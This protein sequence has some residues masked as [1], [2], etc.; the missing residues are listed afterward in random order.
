MASLIKQLALPVT[1]YSSRVEDSVERKCRQTDTLVE[2]LELLRY[3]IALLR[4]RNDLLAQENKKLL[5]HYEQKENEMQNRQLDKS[6]IKA[7]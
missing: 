6:N 2:E 5:D 3:E 4:K 1:T 7:M